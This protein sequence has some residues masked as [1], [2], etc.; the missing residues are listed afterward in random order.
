MILLITLI[1]F[2]RSP[3]RYLDRE[4]PVCAYVSGYK[5]VYK[6]QAPG[7]SRGRRGNCD[8]ADKSARFL[9]PGRPD[10]TFACVRPVHGR[11][12]HTDLRYLSEDFLRRLSVLL[13][14]GPYSK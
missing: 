2:A 8:L 3:S 12:L 9:V 10:C 4:L 1:Y 7:Q 5:L 6:T 14:R 13:M 11:L